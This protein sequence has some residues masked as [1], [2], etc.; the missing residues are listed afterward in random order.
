M[1][2]RSHTFSLAGCTGSWSA[3]C[4]DGWCRTRGCA[5][6]L[7]VNDKCTVAPPRNS[8]SQ[9]HPTD[10][11]DLSVKTFK[12]SQTQNQVETLQDQ[13]Y[14]VYH[15]GLMLHIR[16]DNHHMVVLPE[17]VRH[18]HHVLFTTVTQNTLAFN[19]SS[20]QNSPPP[21]TCLTRRR[22]NTGALLQSAPGDS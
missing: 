8:A 22:L 4:P 20:Y 7:W 13:L 19:K 2:K 18:S 11:K 9:Q 17:A 6:R 14:F 12:R 21:W 10:N 15:K 16:H 3:W 1:L 5:S